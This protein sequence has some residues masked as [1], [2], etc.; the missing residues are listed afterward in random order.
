[1]VRSRINEIKSDIVTKFPNI[2]SSQ[3]NC[4]K[5]E[6][7]FSRRTI[8]KDLQDWLQEKLKNPP[9]TQEDSIEY[10][11][12]IMGIGMKEVIRLIATRCN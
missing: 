7:T 2:K 3:Y 4:N 6:N 12:M 5:L 11:N 1:M 10:K 9:L 8:L